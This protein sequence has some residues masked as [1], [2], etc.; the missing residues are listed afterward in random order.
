MPR[1][2]REIITIQIGQAGSQLG[3]RC[4]E[5][6][7]IEHGVAQDGSLGSNTSENNAYQT[8]YTETSKTKAVPRCLYV[9]LEPTVLDE[10]RKGPCEQLY[11]PHS[12]ISSKED[13]ANNYARGHY[14]IGKQLIDPAL[15]TIRKLSNSCDSLQGFIFMN[16][17]GGG[18]GSGFGAQ[19][20]ERLSGDYGKL[21]KIGFSIYPSPQ[22]ATAVVEPY[23]SVLSTHSFLEHADVSVILDNEGIYDICRRKLDLVQ[24]GYI[25]LNRLVAQ[26]ISSTT[27]SLRFTQDGESN[28]DVSEFRTNLVPFPR[29]HFMFS[30]LAPIIRKEKVAHERL[31]VAELTTAV[32]RPSSVLARCNPQHGKYMSC[33]LM[34]RG[35]VRPKKLNEALNNIRTKRTIQFVEWMPTGFKTGINKQ[36]PAEVPGGDLASTVRSLSMISNSTSICEVFSRIDHKF[37][38]MFAKRAFVHWYVSEGM[39]EGEFIEAREDLTALEKD[40]QEVQD[41]QEEEEEQI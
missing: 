41:E 33:C 23:N 4:W 34:Y 24:P 5:L 22:L 38:V 21:S 8:F 19:I 9:D 13:A 1:L 28:I 36:K 20:L 40:Y 30:S 32:F 16:S 37:D 31:S 12:L 35:D 15:D 17:V 14:T 2:N 27:L 10:I 7:G 3:N 18:T 39:E 6:Y 25:N 26:V 11:H 29:I